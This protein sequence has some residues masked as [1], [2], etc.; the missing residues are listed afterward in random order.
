MRRPIIYFISLVKFNGFA[1]RAEAAEGNHLGAFCKVVIATLHKCISPHANYRL[2]AHF[3]NVRHVH[4]QNAN[5]LKWTVNACD[6]QSL[7]DALL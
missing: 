7:Y 2:Y 4:V 6:Q 5:S 3:Y 1:D